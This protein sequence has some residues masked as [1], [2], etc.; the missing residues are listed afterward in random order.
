[1][2]LLITT[3]DRG[4]ECAKAIRQLTGEAVRLTRDRKAAVAEL[5]RSEFSLVVVEQLLWDTDDRLAD[6]VIGGCGTSALLVTNLAIAGRARVA[7]EASA[8]LR[9]R[10]AEMRRAQDEAELRL[11]TELSEAVTGILL[12][13]ELALATPALPTRA[14]DKIRSV[15]E[16]AMAMRERLRLTA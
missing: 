10:A 7:Q 12:S 4:E 1:M 8:A 6:G 9:R 11:R 14:A 5:R 3:S 13:S 15:Y 16:L 2:V